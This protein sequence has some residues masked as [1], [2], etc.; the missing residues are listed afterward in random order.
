MPTPSETYT[1]ILKIINEETRRLQGLQERHTSAI[2]TRLKVLLSQPETRLETYGPPDYRI[3]PTKANLNKIMRILRAAT[4]KIYPKYWLEGLRDIE[5]QYSILE[6][7]NNAYLNSQAFGFRM[8]PR[9]QA[10]TE[11]AIQNVQ[12]LDNRDLTRRRMEQPIRNMLVE[13]VRTG[14]PFGDLVKT[15]ERSLLNQ[16]ISNRKTTNVD[17]PGIKRSFQEYHAIKRAT[18]DNLFRFSRSYVESVSADLELQ[19]Y[20]YIGG[21]VEDSRPFC[22]ERVGKTWHISEIESWANLKWPEKIPGT[23]A[24]NI[25]VNLGG[26]NC[27]HDM[28]PVSFRKV[29]E[30]DRARMRAKGITLPE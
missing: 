24:T 19:F 13:F 21:L 1:A 28:L 7:V 9:Y 5:N 16:E 17:E 10:I 25:M 11:A 14:A 8:T 3:R 30:S 2:L 20:R 18:R 15:M 29:P 12:A 4:D 6:R 22:R 26:Y 27:R 23:N